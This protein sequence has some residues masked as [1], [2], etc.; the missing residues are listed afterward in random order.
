MLKCQKLAKIGQ[1][2]KVNPLLF[3]RLWP[4]LTIVNVQ[5]SEGK[6]QNVYKQNQKLS[7]IELLKIAQMHTREAGDKK[8]RLPNA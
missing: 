1:E 8:K 3:G 7:K 2:V 5:K 6:T 4:F